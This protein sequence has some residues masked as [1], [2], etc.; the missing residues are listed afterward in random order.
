MNNPNNKLTPAEAAELAKLLREGETSDLSVIKLKLKLMMFA[1]LTALQKKL[2]DA[3]SEAAL[4]LDMDIDVLE[5]MTVKELVDQLDAEVK[6]N[7]IPDT[8]VQS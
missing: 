4:S 8:E 1:Q 3:L 5:T 2:D 7:T 6:K